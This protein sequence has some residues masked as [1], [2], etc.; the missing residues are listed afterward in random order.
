MIIEDTTQG[1]GEEKKEKTGME[2]STIRLTDETILTDRTWRDLVLN[3]ITEAIMFIKRR[4]QELKGNEQATFTTYEDQSKS[5]IL[6]INDNIEFLNSIDQDLQ[7]AYNILTG[8][9]LYMLLNLKHNP[10]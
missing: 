1:K 4:L 9:R 8:K 6:K 3:D 10:M 2:A 5:Q 7:Q